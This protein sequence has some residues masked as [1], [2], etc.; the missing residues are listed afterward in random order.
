MSKEISSLYKKDL[1]TAKDINYIISKK[2]IEYDMKDA[3]FNLIKYYELLNKDKIEYLS[4]LSKHIR[5]VEIG[6]LMRDNNELNKKLTSSFELMRRNFFEENNIKDKD[7]LSIKKD[8]IFII[9]KK[10]KFKLKN[11]EFVEKNVYTSYHRFDNIELYY[12]SKTNVIDVK[13]IKDDLL[14]LHE[15]F[16]NILKRLFKLLE[17]NNMEEFIKLLKRFVSDYK[18][19][20]LSY[21]YYR[22]FDSNSMF[23]LTVSLKNNYCISVDSVDDSI[24][25]LLDI[26]YNYIHY[27]LPIIQRFY[28][29]DI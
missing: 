18:E 14:P 24:D 27:I 12:N 7:V 15:S 3:G 22:C 10:C 28:F 5:K 25:D 21:K 1:Y 2:I 11:V 9:N 23:S 8:A 17:S 19:K 26:S 13:G 6:K 16:I 4:S 29:K 20:R